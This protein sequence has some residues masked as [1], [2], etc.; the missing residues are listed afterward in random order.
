MTLLFL[1]P[2]AVVT[3]V[4]T[5]LALWAVALRRVVPANEVHI[6]QRKGATVSYGKGAEGGNIYYSWP[7]WLPVLG[8]THVVHPVSVFDLNLKAYEAYDKERVPFLV[9]VTAFFRIHDPNTA[10]QR[11][12]DFRELHAQLTSVVQ[13]AVRTI[14]ASHD[15]DSIMVERSKFGEQFT[16]EVE[17]QLKNWGVMPVKNIELMD[18]RDASGSNVIAD[19]MAKR[20]SA[21]QR[22]S[23]VAV[24]ENNRAAE[25]AEIEA[26]REVALQEQNAAQQVG[27]RKAQTT[28]EVGVANEI[29][30][31]QIKE[32]QRETTMKH[33]DVVQVQEVRQA[34]ITKDVKIVK[35]QED[36]E[37]AIV[38]AQGDKQRTILIAEGDLEAKQREATG[39]AVEGQ[40]RAEAEKA[41]Q[42]APVQA[43]IV[44]AQEIGENQGYQH[45][46]LGTREIEAR[47]AIGIKQAEALKDAGIKIIANAGT[48]ADGLSSVS[49]LFSSRGGMKLGAML[50]GLAQTDVG[51]KILPE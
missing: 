10:A 35:A 41:M 4:I 2:I 44:L 7:S 16:R 11:V 39:I 13:G 37:V 40:A 20:T 28:R 46:L 47:E 15:I 33:M 48:P 19:I 45:Y 5:I 50:E 12:S 51:K 21:I 29:A 14:L 36:R 34:E 25:T 32:A 17:E 24:A 30:Q 8:L 6:V 18:I 38:V 49:E 9:D 27:Q 26:Q 43:Q 1:I 42:L 31:Q 23:R 22:D 3:I